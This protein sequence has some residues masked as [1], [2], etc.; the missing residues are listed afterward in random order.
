MLFSRLQR[1]K[2]LS[3]GERM[4]AMPG[5]IELVS[6]DPK[7]QITTEEKIALCRKYPNCQMC[8]Y[9][10]KDYKDAEYHHVERHADGGVSQADNIMVLC[11]NCHHKIH[12][13][14]FEMPTE[15]EFTEVDV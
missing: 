7:R 4:N 14:D 1:G 6:K 8:G 9:K 12:K 10:F 15:D 5:E 13:A 2:P 11:K 3:I